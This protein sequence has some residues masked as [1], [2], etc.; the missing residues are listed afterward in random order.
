MEEFSKELDVG[1][2]YREGSFSMMDEIGDLLQ[3]NIS[4]E[5]ISGEDVIAVR[6]DG[7]VLI[8]SAGQATVRASSEN[9]TVTVYVTIDK[10]PMGTIFEKEIIWDNLAVEADGSTTF[11]LTG[12]VREEAGVRSGDEVTVTATAEVPS[13]R[14]GTYRTSLSDIT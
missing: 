3:G 11:V 2:I 10:V 4:F 8:N 6:D 14:P 1:K 7:T 5:L 13:P 9:G 12:T